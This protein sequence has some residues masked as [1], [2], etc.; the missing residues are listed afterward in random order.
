MLKF[1][2]LAKVTVDYIHETKDSNEFNGNGKANKRKY[3][4]LVIGKYFL[5]FQYKIYWDVIKGMHKPDPM[6][7]FA[8]KVN[9]EK[10]FVSSS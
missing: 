1:E 6:I 10:H 7:I 2:D 5:C 8:I 3:A 4:I 9:P